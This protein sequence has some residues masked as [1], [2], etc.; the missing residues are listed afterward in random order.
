MR[1]LSALVRRELGALFVS[2][3]AYVVLTVFV[4]FAGLRFAF[5]F[6]ADTQQFA[7]GAAMQVLGDMSRMLVLLVPLLTMRLIADEVSTGTFE[8]LTTAPVSNTAVVL[9][10]FLGTLLFLVVMLA[11]TVAFPAML[12]SVASDP[13]VDVGPVIA[14][15]LGLVLLGATAV[16]AGVCVSA[17]VRNPVSAAVATLVV[18]GLLWAGGSLTADGA[19]GR[20]AAAVRYLGVL[21]HFDKGFG[22]GVIDT[23]DAVFY[24]SATGLFLFGAVGVVAVRRWR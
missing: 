24:L 2:P 5:T 11:P 18:L 12:C 8:M 19:G 22:A 7:Y 10:K 14:G 4:L 3:V 6:D 9:S 16:A 13:P 20:L 23:R 21:Y 17:C 15:Y 1:N